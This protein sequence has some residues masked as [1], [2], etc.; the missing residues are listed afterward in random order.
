MGEFSKRFVHRLLGQTR[1]SVHDFRD[2]HAGGERLQNERHGN[3]RAAHPRASAQ[4][5]RG[6]DN[7]VLHASQFNRFKRR[8]KPGKRPS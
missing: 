7:P 6:S 3:A 1:I 4:V 8:L 2:G 5:L